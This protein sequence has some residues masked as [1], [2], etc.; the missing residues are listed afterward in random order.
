[1]I[2]ARAAM[3]PRQ[4]AGRPAMLFAVL[5]A[6]TGLAAQ[7]TYCDDAAAQSDGMAQYYY[8]QAHGDGF[9]SYSGHDLTREYY[10]RRLDECRAG[11]RLEVS[12][13]TEGYDNPVGDA[14]DNLMNWMIFGDQPFTL[15]QMAQELRAIGADA[16]VVSVSSPSCGCIGLGF[17]S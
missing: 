14:A 8:A 15:Q 9:A 17:G 2:A 12:T 7:E 1:M 16:R 4:Q 13:S 6:P 5:V 3:A 10:I 11:L